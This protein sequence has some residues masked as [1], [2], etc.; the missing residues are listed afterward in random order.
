MNY[1]KIVADITA[2]KYKV[3]TLCMFE[4]FWSVGLILLP[5]VAS[6]WNNWTQI[7]MAIS[8]PTV[9]L[10]ILHHWIPDSPRWVIFLK[11]KQEHYSLLLNK[12]V[13]YC[14]Q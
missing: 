12:I 14:A 2:G 8:F 1:Y 3:I 4:Q 10:I 7:Y 11:K 9:A 5:A 13:A 6:F